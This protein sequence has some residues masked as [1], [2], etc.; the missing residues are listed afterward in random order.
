MHPRHQKIQNLPTDQ[1]IFDYFGAGEAFFSNPQARLQCHSTEIVFAASVL[2]NVLPREAI[3]SVPRGLFGR[4]DAESH[5]GETLEFAAAQL[6]QCRRG[7]PGGEWSIHRFPVA[8]A[9]DNETRARNK[10]SMHL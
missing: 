8:N 6:N 1:R 5:T 4:S 10:I 7:H 2:P 3:G 9:L